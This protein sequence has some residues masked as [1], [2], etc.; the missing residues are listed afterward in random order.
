MHT[1]QELEPPCRNRTITNCNAY[2]FPM[3]APKNT[4]VQNHCRRTWHI[5]KK[6]PW[7]AVLLCLGVILCLNCCSHRDTRMAAPQPKVPPIEVSTKAE[8]AT[9]TVGQTITLTVT[10][11]HRHDV[12][13]TMPDIG[14]RIVGLRIVDFGEQGPDRSQARI[15]HT[16]WFSL[17]G[18][19]A[20]SYLIPSFSFLWCTTDNA[21]QREATTP[22]L[23]IEITA[24]SAPPRQND[25][26][27]IKP[28]Y[29]IPRQLLPWIIAAAA[30][31]TLGVAG[32]TVA[33]FIRRRNRHRQ[34]INKTPHEIVYEALERLQ[35]E[36]LIERGKVREYYFKLS[37]I[38]RH[39]IEHRFSIP[40]VEQTTQELIPAIM[41]CPEISAK[42]KSLIREVL[43]Q[44]DMVKFAKYMPASDEI[45]SHWNNIMEIINQT[46]PITEP[47]GQHVAPDASTSQPN[48]NRFGHGG[49]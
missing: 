32:M 16:K 8:P 2:R 22:Q 19:R 15:R 30:V 46:K 36:N 13:V 3:H 14:N 28:Q 34:A 44:A 29:S 38:F 17:K 9:A 21:T 31:L 4:L 10:V 43:A 18:D 12:Q 47:I 40:A 26:Y 11:D 45:Q 6:P 37:E 27:D 48:P 42:T 1:A 49:I 24:P 23:F 5:C 41:S 7:A 25:I 33:W 20:G 39:Y 35:R